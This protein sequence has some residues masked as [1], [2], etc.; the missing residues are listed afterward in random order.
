LDIEKK[1]LLSR[2]KIF[3]LSPGVF[4]H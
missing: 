1:N 2:I 3:M 4:F